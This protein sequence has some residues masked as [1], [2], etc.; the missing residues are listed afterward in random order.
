MHWLQPVYYNWHIYYMTNNFPSS[1]VIFMLLWFQPRFFF[2]Y[3]HAEYKQKHNLSKSYLRCPL[4]YACTCEDIFLHLIIFHNFVS[5]L[6]VSLMLV[7]SSIW[8]I[9]NI[10]T[11]ISKYLRCRKFDDWWSRY[12]RYRLKECQWFVITWN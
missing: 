1:F 7:S 4:L 6:F 10:Y 3:I 9:Q 2:I 12:F 11:C 8:D 5:I